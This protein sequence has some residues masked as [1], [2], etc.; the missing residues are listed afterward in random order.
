M[1]IGANWGEI[2][3]EAIWDTSIWS[4][5]APAYSPDPI[6]INWSAI[7]DDRIWDTTIWEQ[8]VSEPP[9]PTPVA[10][11][12]DSRSMAGIIRIG[13]LRRRS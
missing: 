12:S 10:S 13:R 2:W 5:T 3:D 8:D 6:G 1:A 11:L 9:L 4:N 7:W